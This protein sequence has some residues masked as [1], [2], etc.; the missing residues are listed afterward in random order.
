MCAFSNGLFGLGY[1][2]P[3]EP[4][5]NPNTEKVENLLGSIELNIYDDIM[6]RLKDLASNISDVDGSIIKDIQDRITNSKDSVAKVDRNILNDVGNKLEM[7]SVRQTAL[8]QTAKQSNFDLN[9]AASN[10]M[11]E[12]NRERVTDKLRSEVRAYQRAYSEKNP[13]EVVVER[14]RDAQAQLEQV[15]KQAQKAA[16]DNYATDGSNSPN[17]DSFNL[18]ARRINTGGEAIG[19]DP[20]NVGDVDLSDLPQPVPPMIMPPTRPVIVQPPQDAPQGDDPIPIPGLD[21]PP[22]EKP[23]ESDIPEWED[24][25]FPTIPVPVG[26]DVEQ[27]WPGGD[28]PGEIP[29]GTECPGCDTVPCICLPSVVTE[30]P[31]GRYEDPPTTMPPPGY[32]GGPPIRVDVDV[33][34]PE[35]VPEEPKPQYIFWCHYPSGRSWIQKAGEPPRNPAAEAVGAGE[36][37]Q[38]AIA[39]GAGKCYMTYRSVEGSVGPVFERENRYFCSPTAYNFD[40]GDKL[41]VTSG[42]LD[43]LF[44]KGTLGLNPETLDTISHWIDEAKKFKFVSSEAAFYMQGAI[45]LLRRFDGILG[46]LLAIFGSDVSRFQ[47]SMAMRVVIGFFEQW[48]TS[49]L[50]YI[51]TPYVYASQEAMPFK[52][53]SEIQAMQAF[54]SAQID[55]PTWALWTRMNG[56]CVEPMSKLLQYYRTKFDP[57]LLLGMK[58]RGIINPGQYSDEFRHWGYMDDDDPKRYEEVNRYVP[59]IQDLVRFMVRDV[60]DNDVINELKLSEGFPQKWVGQARTW[61]EYQGIDPE[62]ALKYWQAHW[63]IPPSGQLYDIFHREKIR[64]IDPENPFGYEKLK[65]ALQIQDNN[66]A[67]VPYLIKLSQHLLTRVDVRRAY[68]LGILNDNEVKDN[69]IMR[70]YDELDAEALRKYAIKDKE[71]F[72]LARRETKL[73]RDG[74]IGEQ[75]WRKDVLQYK[76]TEQQIEYVANITRLERAKPLIKK[77]TKN[78]EKQFIEREINDEEARQALGM[79]GLEEDNINLIMFGLQCVRR[80]ESKNITAGKLCEMYSRFIITRDGFLQRLL[81]IGYK[82]RDAWLLIFNCDAAK[83]EK[84]DAELA[85]LIKQ[86]EREREKQAKDAKRA[87]DKARAKGEQMAKARERRKLAEDRR[88]LRQLKATQKLAKCLAV[89]IE[90]ATSLVKEALLGMDTIYKFTSEERTTLLERSVDKC[91]DMTPAGFN[92]TWL[93]IANSFARLE[94][95]GLYNVG[96][97]SSPDSVN[98][99][100]SPGNNGSTGK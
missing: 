78:I 83:K 33:Q 27:I 89:D 51:K 68:R 88:E 94:E 66:P 35:E 81:D 77:C 60:F 69:Y 18:E 13:I 72:L 54:M 87:A 62:I 21:F 23:D 11:R 79:I 64:P 17:P 6:H 29:V 22:S 40:I 71:Q 9:T 46:P 93:R 70:G 73:F 91:K 67:F 98:P 1:G 30:C 39:N 16:G 31:P 82:E 15:I 53:P 19:D 52:F 37:P 84:D 99:V 28:I 14:R 48:F 3:D 86:Q 65:R 97:A 47:E 75:R 61:G 4:N 57:A 8:N 90:I 41:N 25:E 43:H 36:T 50:G 95:S 74:V 32:P 34:L 7:A 58:R 76:P 55:A 2:T 63:L 12:A 24:P 56:Y 45:G 10:L 42:I 44:I 38:Q 96:D 85:R 80:T 49:D 92:N 59:P 20:A 26:E 100:Q 5:N